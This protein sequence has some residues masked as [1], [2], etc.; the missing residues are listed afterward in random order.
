MTGEHREL[1]TLMIPKS[2]QTQPLYKGLQTNHVYVYLIYLS[3]ELNLMFL[4][5][6]FIQKLVDD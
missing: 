2:Q 5:T 6:Q 4:N 1:Y 3:I